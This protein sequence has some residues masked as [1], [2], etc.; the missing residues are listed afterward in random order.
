M[1]FIRSDEFGGYLFLQGPSVGAKRASPD[2]E[3]IS[4][5]SFRRTLCQ[6]P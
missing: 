6:K 4:S 1:I 3:L 2:L 5:F